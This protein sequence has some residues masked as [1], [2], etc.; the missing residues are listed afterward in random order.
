M[1][2]VSGKKY[3][4]GGVEGEYCHCDYCK[5]KHGF[6][7]EGYGGCKGHKK[8]S[9]R[10]L[11]RIKR[12]KEFL[13]CIDK[14]ANRWYCR[15]QEPM[16]KKRW[17]FCRPVV[18]LSDIDVSN[19]PVHYHSHCTSPWEVRW[20]GNLYLLFLL[21]GSSL[22]PSGHFCWDKKVMI[23]RSLFISEIPLQLTF[24][25]NHWVVLDS[26]AGY[27]WL[28]GTMIIEVSLSKPL[29]SPHN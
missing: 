7:Q 16:H 26:T 25:Y 21:F 22:Q 6:G 1:S 10:L 20:P 27:N 23:C 8:W 18:I 15:F 19:Q 17:A 29:I 5:C 28:R 14:T 9:G 3:C 11:Q 24:G 4:Y 13:C 2:I 12:T